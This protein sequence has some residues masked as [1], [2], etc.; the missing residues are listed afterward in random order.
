M[1]ENEKSGTL[2]HPGLWGCLRP[3]P[4][5]VKGL[6]FFNRLMTP[7]SF[8]VMFSMGGWWLSPRSGSGVP[9]SVEKTYVNWRFKI[10]ALALGSECTKPPSFSGATPELSQRLDFTNAPSFLL[11]PPAGTLWIMSWTYLL[12]DWRQTFW[13]SFLR[14]LKRVQSLVLLV[15]RAFLKTRF[16]R[17]KMR[18]DAELNHGWLALVELI[19]DGMHSSMILSSSSWRVVART[20]TGV[21]VENLEVKSYDIWLTLERIVSRS[22]LFQSNI[23]RLTGFR[24]VARTFASIKTISW[25][26][27][28]GSPEHLLVIEGLLV[29]MTSKV[30]SPLVGKFTICSSPAV[31]SK[32]KND[33][34]MANLYW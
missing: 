17:L 20:S 13:A 28:P 8:T 29:I 30:L 24:L 27:R 22:A 16:F 21:D 32:F 31:S 6:R 14:R 23:L 26:L 34:L 5:A 2:A 10:F 4:E 15:R 11:L 25:S 7:F 12:Y 1:R 18:L 19:L 9:L 33:S 3:W